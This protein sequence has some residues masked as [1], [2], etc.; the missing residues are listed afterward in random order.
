MAD[1]SGGNWVNTY[2][3]ANGNVC[4]LC[5]E[6]VNELGAFAVEELGT[7]ALA[8]PQIKVNGQTGSHT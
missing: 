2:L 4:H 7:N 6:T 5:L 3:T 8:E 1:K